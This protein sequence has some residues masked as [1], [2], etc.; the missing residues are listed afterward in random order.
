VELD[1]LQVERVQEFASEPQADVWVV[2]LE[3]AL[4]Q[5]EQVSGG[6]VCYRYVWVQKVLRVHCERRTRRGV[7]PDP[8]I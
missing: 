1:L 5:G 2:Q 7:W 8:T 3:L 6:Q 4:Q